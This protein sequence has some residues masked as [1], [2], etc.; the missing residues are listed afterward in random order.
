MAY[1]LVGFVRPLGLN[2]CQELLLSNRLLMSIHGILIGLLFSFPSAVTREAAK[3]ALKNVSLLTAHVAAFEEEMT[4]IRR[5][6]LGDQDV[7]ASSVSSSSSSS[8]ASSS[9]QLSSSSPSSSTISLLPSFDEI[10]AKLSLLRSNLRDNPLPV[11][12][13]A[14]L[15]GRLTSE[16][17]PEI[18]RLKHVQDL[19]K[20]D[21]I[22]AWIFDQLSRSV[23]E[24]GQ[25]E[26]DDFGTD[27]VRGSEGRESKFG[28]Y[29]VRELRLTLDGKLDHFATKVL[30]LQTYQHYPLLIPVFSR[31]KLTNNILH[32]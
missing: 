23:D 22:A 7:A 12:V 9:S 27:F 16:F 32:E 15:E 24:G 3:E 13:R 19:K 30:G 14:E 20:K 28:K 21:A 25:H 2:P 5:A 8:S 6:L 31:N 11:G 18:A 26:Q 10:E 29:A 1:L 17:G 4:N